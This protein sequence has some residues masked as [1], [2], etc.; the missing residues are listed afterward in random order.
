MGA[1]AM[2]ADTMGAHAMRPYG[3]LGKGGVRDVKI[4]GVPQSPSH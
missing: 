3:S 2:E 1:Y 4:A